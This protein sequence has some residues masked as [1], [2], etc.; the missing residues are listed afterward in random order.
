MGLDSKIKKMV[1][2]IISEKTK[3]EQN[4]QTILDTISKNKK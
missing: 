3:F 1:K 4:Y 2:N